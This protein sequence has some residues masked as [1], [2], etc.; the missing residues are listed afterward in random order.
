MK[1]RQIKEDA[2]GTDTTHSRIW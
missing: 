2:Q 1:S